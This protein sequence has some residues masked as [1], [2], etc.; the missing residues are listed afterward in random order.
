M[1]KCRSHIN[2]KLST[3]RE[4]RLKWISQ[5]CKHTWP[6]LVHT[7]NQLAIYHRDG[8]K[9]ASLCK[10]A[11]LTCSMK[12]QQQNKHEGRTERMKNTQCFSCTW[13]SDE[14]C[15]ELDREKERR[16][17]DVTTR[18]GLPSLSPNWQQTL[19]GALAVSSALGPP[20]FFLLG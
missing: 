16:A 4:P 10:H 12:V 17:R 20:S 7:T 8:L 18:G 15:G 6:A 11:H 3:V 5:V 13:W 14:R 9:A 2:S 1:L 19:V